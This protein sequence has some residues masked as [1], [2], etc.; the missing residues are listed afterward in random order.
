MKN[1][2]LKETKCATCNV[3]WVKPF[4]NHQF[5]MKHCLWCLIH[6]DNEEAEH[7]TEIYIT[8]NDRWLNTPE[9]KQWSENNE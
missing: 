5:D 8:L 4:L 1:K 9:G 7:Y 6:S 2:E 3:E